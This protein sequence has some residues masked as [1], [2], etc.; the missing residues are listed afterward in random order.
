[1]TVTA[2]Q[3]RDYRGRKLEK[4]KIWKKSPAGMGAC[5][6]WHLIQ[7]FG[8]DKE[9]HTSAEDKDV[10]SGE[11]TGLE[12]KRPTTILKRNCVCQSRWWLVKKIRPL[13]TT[14]SNSLDGA[15]QTDKNTHFSCFRTFLPNKS[16][17]CLKHTLVFRTRQGS[18]LVCLTIPRLLQPVSPTDGLNSAYAFLP[19]MR[20]HL[21]LFGVYLQSGF[22]HLLRPSHVQTH[23]EEPTV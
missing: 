6:V 20:L 1:M 2:I 4:K 23:R 17:P 19:L 11:E 10:V 7:M 3:L 16:T 18:G 12:I 5:I 8:G 21:F 22:L 15:L 9:N 14:V 13:L